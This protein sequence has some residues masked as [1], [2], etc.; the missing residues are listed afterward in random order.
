[1]GPLNRSGPPPVDLTGDPTEV[2]PT[3]LR[4]RIDA[5]EWVVDLR[6][7]RA[8]AA[9][10]L[11]GS[12]GFELSRNFVTY[13]GWLYPYGDTSLTL[14]GESPEQVAQARRELVRIG[15]DALAGAATGDVSD[16]TGPTPLRSYPVRDFAALA[17]TMAAR[18]VTRPRRA[19]RRRA[20]TGRR[21]GG[22][23]T[24]PCTSSRTV[25]TRSPAARCGCTA[26]RGTGRRSRRPSSTAPTGTWSWSTTPT[27]PRGTSAWRRPSDRSRPGGTPQAVTIGHREL[28]CDRDAA[29]GEHRPPELHRHPVRQ[30]HALDDE[31]GVRGAPPEHPTL[32][33]SEPHRGE[34]LVPAGDGDPAP[35]RA[36]F[37]LGHV[38]VQQRPADAVGQ[39]EPVPWIMGQALA[40]HLA[41]MPGLAD[42]DRDIAWRLARSAAL[43]ATSRHHRHPR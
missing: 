38:G 19:P 23:C 35:P 5:G 13:L 28:R 21:R 37:L 16:L 27:T 18:A 14:I 7:R 30:A 15:I 24:F 1:M 12:L 29:G 41:R 17:E 6:D 36:A 8:F 42:T 39:L 40:E 31:P 22:P 11:A 10:H 20:G 34:P 3:E 9:G 26:A 43:A 25:A 4:R 2:D 33:R 32:V